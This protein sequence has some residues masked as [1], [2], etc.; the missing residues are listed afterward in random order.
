ML[1]RHLG[2]Q[3]WID[4]ENLCLWRMRLGRELQRKYQ[5]LTEIELRIEISM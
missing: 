3:R 1:R 5:L 2:K 4:W